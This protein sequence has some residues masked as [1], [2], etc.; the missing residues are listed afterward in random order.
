MDKDDIESRLEQCI[1]PKLRMKLKRDDMK[2]VRIA[3]LAKRLMGQTVAHTE[4]RS[5]VLAREPGEEPLTEVVERTYA[6]Y[7]SDID[8]NATT[9]CTFTHLLSED[10]SHWIKMTKTV[11]KRCKADTLHILNDKAKRGK[12]RK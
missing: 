5:R 6:G 8:E 4:R 11:P 7:V 2:S 9:S 12:V 3:K 1:H 10:R